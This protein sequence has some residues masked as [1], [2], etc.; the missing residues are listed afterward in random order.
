VSGAGAVEAPAD[1]APAAVAPGVVRVLGRNATGASQLQDPKGLARDAT[2]RLY[3]VQDQA[4]RIAVLNPDGSVA[5]TLGGAGSGD[6]QFQEPWGMTVAPNG[7]LYVADTW[8]HRIQKFDASG[9]FL[10]KWGTF[11]D[12]KGQRDAEPGG[13]WGPR[14]VAIGPDGNVY[15]T[16]T[17][18]KRIQVF[19]PNG[20]FLRAIGGEGSGPG[21]FREPVGIAFDAAG[22]LWVADTWNQR[23]QKLSASGQQ[24][25]QY[26][27]PAWSSQAITNK[28]YLS[29]DPSGRVYATVP[30][31]RR[32]LVVEPDGRVG[33]APA[34][35]GYSFQLPIGVLAGPDGALWV[36]DSRAGVVVEV[37]GQTASGSPAAESGQDGSRS[38]GDEGSAP[39]AP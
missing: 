6:G 33:S 7:D 27:V 24:L 1:A 32:V 5:T 3:V 28:P 14:D 39:G 29:A 22:N 34:L 30:E 4:N 37:A 13:L 38:V 18:N 15:V 31:E 10:T 36:S 21:Q 2:G 11:I 23:I 9:R 8:N 12:A 35:Q 20:R 19:D 25:A 26:P 17:G 16:D